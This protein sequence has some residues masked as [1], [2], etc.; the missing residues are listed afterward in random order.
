MTLDEQAKEKL[1]SLDINAI[2][3]ITSAT[4]FVE[5]LK[6]K[7]VKDKLML[8]DEQYNSI[9]KVLGDVYIEHAKISKLNLVKHPD[10]LYSLFYQDGLQHAFERLLTTK[11]SGQN[12]CAQKMINTIKSYDVLIKE[13]LH[14]G[15]Y[16]DVAY[17]TGY[18]AGLV[19]FLLDKKGR[20]SMPMYFLFGCGDIMNFEQ[21]IELEKDAARS[22]KSAH[23]MAEKI[24]SRASKGLVFHYTPFS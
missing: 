22:H 17:F 23:K 19:Y 2:P 13:H 21:Y 1:K 16:P 9:D 18:Q 4:F 14:E 11:K 8:P 24:A 3:I 12:S 7:L 5:Q 15:K 6:K 10:A 20:R